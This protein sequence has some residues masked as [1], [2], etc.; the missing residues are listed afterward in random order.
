MLFSCIYCKYLLLNFDSSFHFL[1]CALLKE[2]LI[3]RWS[4]IST[5]S[6]DWHILCLL[7]KFLPEVR[8]ILSCLVKYN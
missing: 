7:R 8:K 5:H 1:K 6:F 2:V 4:R 3:Q